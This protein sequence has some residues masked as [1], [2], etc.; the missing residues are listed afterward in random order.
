[1]STR[2]CVSGRSFC[3]VALVLALPAVGWGQLSGRTF[4]S[5]I[6]TRV[7]PQQDLTA[8]QPE[9]G[10]VPAA[11]SQP[12]PTDG[13]VLFPREP[14]PLSTP[15]AQTEGAWHAGRSTGLKPTGAGISSKAGPKPKSK[16]PS[17]VE[18][19]GAEGDPSSKKAGPTD[20]EQVPEGFTGLFSEEVQD[21]AQRVLFVWKYPF[22]K[23]KDFDLSLQVIIGGLFL[24]WLGNKLARRLSAWLGDTVL[25][26]VGLP[27]ATAAPLQKMSFY[28]LFGAF[29]VF[30]LQ[31]VGVPMTVFTFFGGAL[32]I[33]IGFG[34]QNVMNNFI[35]G[36]ILLIERPIR[37][38]DVIQIDSHSGKVSEIGARSTRITTGSNLEVIIPNSTFL[39]GNVVN[40]TL[41]DDIISS[42]VA[43]GVAYGSPAREVARLLRQAAETHEQILKT[44][45]PGVS[46]TEFA[47]DSMQFELSFWLKMSQADRGKVESDL[48]FK[49]DELF[50]GR[51]IVIAYPQRD[52]HL[53]LL[54]PV[55]VRLSEPT[56]APRELRG[57]A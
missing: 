30:S 36:L 22:F 8:E 20:A 29:A 5:N 26:R 10:V 18:K 51:G 38:G 31:L 12:L 41:S 49:I 2:R 27:A 11:A 50:A 39:Q 14:A 32:A 48:R 40:W 25:R 37:V 53:N 9:A 6:P 57:A 46:F 24:L 3:A 1:M 23:T 47:A 13:E 56:V 19:T 34:S 42:K 54:R 43:V 17:I 28:V 35:S 15:A 21:V 45:A 4:R 16:A 7:L 52:V 55:E 33:G 44:P